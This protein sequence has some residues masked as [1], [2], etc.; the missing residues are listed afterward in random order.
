[1]LLAPPSFCTCLLHFGF[2]PCS[3]LYI[4]MISFKEDLSRFAGTLEVSFYNY[5]IHLSGAYKF[6]GIALN[7]KSPWIPGTMGA[8]QPD[9]HW[10]VHHLSRNNFPVM[11]TVPPTPKRS[12]LSPQ[13]IQIRTKIIIQKS[14]LIQNI[15]ETC[16]CRLNAGKIK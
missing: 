16:C 5:P 2:D 6:P 13:A 1:M 11:E 3:A 4:G 10:W 12:R 15:L 14:I 7:L 9:F 8:S